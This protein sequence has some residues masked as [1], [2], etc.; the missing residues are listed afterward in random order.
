MEQHGMMLY[1]IPPTH[2]HTS[3]T[4]VYVLLL[5]GAIHGF[6]FTCCT[7]SISL[8]WPHLHLLLLCGCLCFFSYRKMLKLCGEAEDKLAQ[9]LIHFELQVERDV[10]EPLFVLAEVRVH[11]RNKL[12]E[13]T[14][15]W[16]VLNRKRLCNKGCVKVEEGRSSTTFAILYFAWVVCLEVEQVWGTKMC[17]SLEASMDFPVMLTIQVLASL[18]GAGVTL[19]YN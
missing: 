3:H 7:I 12:L 13:W 8:T 14:L 19:S 4:N 6:C 1:P 10:I 9:E 17:P 18:M 11:L 15:Y 16:I 5:L 2:T